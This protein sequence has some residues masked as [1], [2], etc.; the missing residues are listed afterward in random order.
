MNYSIIALPPFEK[1]LKRLS[2]KFPSLRSDFATFIEEL[3]KNPIQGDKEN[4]SENELDRLLKIMTET[5]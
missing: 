2:K 1:E 4:I 5:I 3:T